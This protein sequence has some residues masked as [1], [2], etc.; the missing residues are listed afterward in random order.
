MQ[1]F[2]RGEKLGAVANLV[3]FYVDEVPGAEIHGD[4][5]ELHLALEPGHAQED[6]LGRGHIKP[7]TQLEE[8]AFGQAG[9]CESAKDVIGEA[10][11]RIFGNEKRNRLSTIERMLRVE[12][13]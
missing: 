8:R 13:P 6:Q 12:R 10:P 2:W 11:P 9:R 7:L 3:R 1:L 5:C 4:L